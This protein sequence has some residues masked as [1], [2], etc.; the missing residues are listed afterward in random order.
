MARESNVIFYVTVEDQGVSEDNSLML[1]GNA[2][3]V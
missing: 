1:E 2:V 3:I